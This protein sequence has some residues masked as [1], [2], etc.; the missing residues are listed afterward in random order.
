MGIFGCWVVCIGVAVVAFC[1]CSPGGWCS[2]IEV[3]GDR[4]GLE[5]VYLSHVT[6]AVQLS[7]AC[8]LAGWWL[9]VLLVF[10]DELESAAHGMDDLRCGGAELPLL[11]H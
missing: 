10:T 4:E 2:L 8:W 7:E 6:E 11:M 1:A 5:L 9:L 3:Q